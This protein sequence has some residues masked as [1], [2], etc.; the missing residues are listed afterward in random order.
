MTY[1]FDELIDRTNTDSY[2]WDKYKDRDIIPLWVA[3]MDFKAAPPILKALEEVTK[4]GVIGYWHAPDELADVIVKRLEERHHW[5]IEKEWIVYLPGLVPGLTLSCIV[6][7]NDGDE[8]ITTVPVYGPF[9][10]APEAAKKKLV[11]VQMK[12]ENKRWTFDFDAIRAAIT[13]R[14]RMFML[15]NPYNPAGTVF[16]KEELQMLIDICLEN[17]I[18][19]CSDEIHCDLILDESKKHMSIATLSK[20]A[21]NQTITLLSPSKTFNIAGLGCSFAVI[22]NDEIRTKFTNLK[23]IVEP[24]SSAYAYQAAL[25]AYR[26]C[27]EWHEQLLAYLRINHDYVL[28]E[29]NAITGFS[30]MPLE[31]T[32]LAWIDTRESGNDN[33]AEILENAGVGVSEGGFYFEGRGFIR[34]NFGTQMKQ[35][36]AAIWRMRKVLC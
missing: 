35:L 36:E 24:M 33:I 5:K 34:L 18:V 32:Y 12:L 10:K 25:S 15:C 17:K 22:P 6:V 9:M 31:S 29:M 11:K 14:T 26:D 16:S 4:Q 19:I 23:Y 30:M 8:I 27:D 7:G 21:E 20:E 2:K 13:P 1:D 28:Y 3:D